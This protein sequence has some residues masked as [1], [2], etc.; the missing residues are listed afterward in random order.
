LPPAGLRLRDG[1]GSARGGHVSV[2]LMWGSS[3]R[4]LDAGHPL[5]GAG[6]A[7]QQ[8]STATSPDGNQHQLSATPTVSWDSGQTPSGA[9]S[10]GRRG[11]LASLWATRT[12]A[13]NCGVVPIAE[14]RP[15][16]PMDRPDTGTTSGALMLPGSGTRPTSVQH[17]LPQ[18]ID[19][20]AAW[21]GSD[22]FLLLM[23]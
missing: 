7:I 15:T 17:Q 1:P 5:H 10:S 8:P 20:L 19:R 21:Q 13:R 6:G 2:W 23:S 22:R 11:R 4:R 3:S 18:S 16:Y 14:R 9:A 12:D